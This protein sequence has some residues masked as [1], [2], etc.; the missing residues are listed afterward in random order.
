MSQCEQRHAMFDHPSGKGSTPFGAAC[1]FWGGEIAPLM[2]LVESSHF[3][4]FA[5][6]SLHDFDGGP[7]RSIGRLEKKRLGA[8]K[9]LVQLVT[10]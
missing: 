3:R 7:L 2:T 1:R 10:E 9:R 8:S 4:C 6:V 5:T